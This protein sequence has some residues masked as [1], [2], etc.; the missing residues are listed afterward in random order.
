MRDWVTIEAIGR[1]GADEGVD[2]RAVEGTRRPASAE[3]DA[4]VD[5][6]DEMELRRTSRLWLIQCKRE[7][8][9]GPT[10]ARR[11]ARETVPEGAVVPSVLVLA[12]ACDFS[13]ATRQAFRGAAA[14][15]GIEEIHL[16][17]KA[18]L[19]DMLFTPG[20]DHLLFA[21]FN[22]SLQV[23]RRSLRTE[24]RSRL[25]LKRQL[26]NVLGDIGR[27]HHESVL[28]RDAGDER[29]GHIDP[30]DAED[31]G[32]RWLACLGSL[33]P[34]ILVFRGA[35]F[36]AWISEDRAEYDYVD[37]IDNAE[38][39]DKGPGRRSSRSGDM[40]WRYFRWE[41]A[42]VPKNQ[43]ASL[44]RPLILPYERIVL[45]DDIGDAWNEAPHILVDG[46][47]DEVF[48]P[49]RDLLEIHHYPSPMELLSADER[50]RVSFFPSEFPEVPKDDDIPGLPRDEPPAAR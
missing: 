18:E 37:Q 13:H 40:R 46:P 29:Y 36:P 15:L 35:S 34:D 19:E 31:A 44:L 12:A 47:L 22:I 26:V 30:E 9:I 7:R 28:V 27:D 41:D 8:Q 23:R 42:N 5:D 2:I 17:G 48:I 43:R 32:W 16:W 50:Q 24:L 21:Y 45:V 3:G 1:T 14:E 39:H 4:D 33:Q 38:V 10:K 6:L 20:N 49:G 11:Y 25:A